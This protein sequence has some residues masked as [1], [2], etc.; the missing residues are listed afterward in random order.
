MEICKTGY[1]MYNLS[2]YIDKH[3]KNKIHK[4]I[5]LLLT[6]LEKFVKN[7]DKQKSIFLTYFDCLSKDFADIALFLTIT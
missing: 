3:L 7:I 6:T 1:V 2:Y 4:N 5:V